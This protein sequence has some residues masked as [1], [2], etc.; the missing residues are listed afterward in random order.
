MSLTEHQE[1][2]RFSSWLTTKGLKHSAIPN[3][4][5]IGKDRG[6][7]MAKM[8]WLEAE[9]FSKGLPDM[10]IIVPYKNKEVVVFIE[11]KRADLKP[12]RNGKGGVSDAQREWLEA[13]DRCSDVGAYVAYGCEDAKNIINKI[14]QA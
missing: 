3:G 2:I 6:A 14:I 10:L 1:Q 5:I 12:K 9:G 11:M 7:S 8:K 13:L 4:M